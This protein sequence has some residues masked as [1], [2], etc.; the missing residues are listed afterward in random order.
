MIIRPKHV[1]VKGDARRLSTASRAK[2]VEMVVLGAIG[3]L[4][5]K[6]KVKVKDTEGIDVQLQHV[7]TRRYC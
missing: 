7:Q 6:T 1:L 2:A 4:L 5:A 3:E